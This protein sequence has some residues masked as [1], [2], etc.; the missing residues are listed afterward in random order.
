MQAFGS[1]VCTALRMVTL[2]TL[3]NVVTPSW[4][5][6]TPATGA[7][8][9]T[10][11]AVAQCQPNTTSCGTVP[12]QHHQLCHNASSAPP[13][14]SQC[15]LSNTSCVTASRRRTQSRIE[16]TAGNWHLLRHA[17]N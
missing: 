13:A 2:S 1:C 12:A 7:C 16:N 15:Q 11:P 17:A 4:T 10:P 3:F 6:K 5:H 8:S 9:P 14:V